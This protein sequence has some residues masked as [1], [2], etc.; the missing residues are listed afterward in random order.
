M[1]PPPIERNHKENDRE[2]AFVLQLIIFFITR[3]RGRVKKLYLTEKNERH[4]IEILIHQ[5]ILKSWHTIRMI[6]K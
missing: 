3:L 2:H 4:P 5:T 1:A 6:A